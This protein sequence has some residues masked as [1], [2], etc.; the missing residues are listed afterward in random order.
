MHNLRNWLFETGKISHLTTNE[1][2]LLLDDLDQNSVGMSASGVF[3]LN[4]YFV[5]TVF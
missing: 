1:I 3:T 5:G 2:V 4:Y